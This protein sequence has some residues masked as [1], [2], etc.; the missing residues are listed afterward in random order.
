MKYL[1]LIGIVFGLG[2]VF[3][4][5]QKIYL[6]YKYNSYVPQI[7]TKESI[8][9]FLKETKVIDSN[10]VY[11]IKDTLMMNEMD[12]LFCPNKIY[13]FDKSGTVLD[14]NIKKEEGTCYADL[15]K[16]M[17]SG[18]DL[19]NSNFNSLIKNRFQT[20]KQNIEPL[21]ENQITFEDFEYIIVFGWAKYFPESCDADALKFL[22]CLKSNYNHVYVVA[23]N[24]DY[25]EN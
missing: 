11:R 22:E 10:S 13:I 16:K 15:I 4:I 2:I 3:L 1:K 24:F 12:N 20:L 7:E 8:L 9:K 18:A 14:N 19:K 5:G 23:L 17:C 25:Y 21:I 6:T